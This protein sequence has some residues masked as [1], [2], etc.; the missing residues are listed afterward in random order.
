M[1]SLE[2]IH[3]AAGAGNVQKSLGYLGTI[4]SS[5][6]IN[7]VFQW[8]RGPEEAI[9]WVALKKES[10]IPIEPFKEKIRSRL[11]AALP[12]V[13]FSFE[14]ADIVNEVM[15]FG[16]PT[17]VEVAVNGPDFV[18]TRP[19]AARILQ[20]MNK[21]PGLRDLQV[22]QSLN[23]PMVQ[24]DVD[25]KKAGTV[26][27][28][29][30]DVAKSLTEA[31]SSSRFTT[32]NFWADPKSGIGYQVQVEVPRPVVRS[33]EGIKPIGSIEDLKMVPVKRNDAGQ[34]LLRDVA[35]VSAG[36]MPGEIDRYNMKRQVSMTANLAG[37][38]LGS[39][40]RQVA[41][42]LRRAGEPPPGVKVE[43]RG[44]IPPMRDMLSGLS[45]GLAMAIVVIFLLLAANFQS[46]RLSL[47]TVS[48]APA[49]IA[50][51]VVMLWLTG[52]TLNIQS[53]IGAIMAVGVAMAN[54]ILLV[55]FAENH[56]QQGEPA[57]DAAVAGARPLAP[58]LMTTCAMM[59][60]MLPM[61]L[62]LGES[63]QQNAPLG[64]AVIG[65]LA[66][67][68]AATLFVL[69]S[70]FAVV[71]RRAGRQSASLD[72]DDPHTRVLC[73]WRGEQV[74][75]PETYR[76]TQRTR[77]M[78]RTAIA[79]GLLA[80]AAIGGIGY[81]R[82]GGPGLRPLESCAAASTPAAASPLRV[83]AVGPVR[84]TLR[85]EIGQPGQIEA[86]EFTPL[87]AKLP[88]YVQKLYVDIGDRVSSDQLL[89]ELFLPELKDELRQKEAAMA[90]AQAQIDL[91]AA[92][93]RA[94]EAAVATAQ[95]NIRLAEAG[96]IRAEADVVRWQ[97]QYARISQL[98]AAGSVDRKLEDETR[99]QL[100]AAEAALGETR[101]KLE[102]A[103]A[104]LS[105]DQA[106]LAKAKAAQSVA[107]AQQGNAEAD[108][109]RVKSLLRYTQ[110]RA[111][112]AGVVT[113]RNVNRGDFVQPA[114]TTSAKPLLA[115]ARTD[116]VRIFVA[117]PEM[118]S[119]WVEAGCAGYVS[120]QAL[121]DRI[122]EGKVTR[123]SWAL[124]A[125]RTLNVELDLPN[126]G[127]LLRPG[128]YA[129]AH[130]VLQ[131]RRNAS[132]LPLSAIVREG[133]QAFCW[134][135]RD[136]KATRLPIGLGLQVGSDAEVVSGLN[137]TD[138]V[139]QSPAA[140]LHEG[141]PVEV[142]GP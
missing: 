21:L 131:E 90:Q 116:I 122:V 135:V 71:Q 127:G 89:V 123:T 1:K 85:L 70:I 88:S 87:F 9:M 73:A 37:T 53:L 139:V 95:A 94:A 5:Y 6:P 12:D 28:T 32:A 47:A 126:P 114:N 75:P 136:G 117:V 17:P 100:K 19:Y 66:A 29:P 118:E 3:D 14:P 110:I 99:D 16:S 76:M 84:K 125:N 57:S 140:S 51:V 18:Q 132:V 83:T 104:M 93:V 80:A 8:M 23:Y 22:V 101:A 129:T 119:P 124:G 20:E 141:Q 48:T 112:Y 10:G 39:V 44:Q 86:F 128:M 79:L 109:S 74:R 49:G 107:L 137:E 26:Y 40:S 60:G 98:V 42:A 62:A 24:V 58:I 13:H 7:G 45:V 138:V 81:H 77:I 65:G 108:A 36:V 64:R 92:A 59:A 4:G 52:T 55:T 46:L 120:V 25:R 82:W 105:Q 35:T 97:S 69:P 106:D 115:V 121:P 61:A 130:I 91:A 33:P 31:T 34:V 142:A 67:A 72:P 11:A 78:K 103:K 63:G 134:A 133:K 2:V 111:P 38:D 68:T 43:V 41:A 56:R 102:A 30:N 27:V 54:A 113:Q 50:G 15:S 96:L